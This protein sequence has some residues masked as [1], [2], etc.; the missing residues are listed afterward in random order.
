LFYN[1]GKG[2]VERRLSL[3]N[4]YTPKLPNPKPALC[5]YGNE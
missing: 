5:R 1:R 4:L 3:K 2:F